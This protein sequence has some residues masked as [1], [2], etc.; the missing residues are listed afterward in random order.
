MNI[1]QWQDRATA[2]ICRTGNRTTRAQRY[3]ESRGFTQAHHVR[4]GM[5]GSDAG[6]GWIKRGWPGWPPPAF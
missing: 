1:C 6:P 2:L 5:P 3:P 4:E